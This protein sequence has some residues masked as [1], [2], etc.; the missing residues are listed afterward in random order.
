MDSHAMTLRKPGH[1]NTAC[2]E[3]LSGT[4]GFTEVFASHRSP[5]ADC[6]P[7]DPYT[8]VLPIQPYSREARSPGSHDECAPHYAAVARRM[9]FMS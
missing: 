2:V 4:K 5:R 3:W 7:H 6:T 9:G 8:R 1:N